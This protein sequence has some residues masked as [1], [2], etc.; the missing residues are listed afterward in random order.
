M[1]LNEAQKKG[2]KFFVSVEGHDHQVSAKQL[3]TM[4]IDSLNFKSMLVGLDNTQFIEWSEAHGVVRCSA[5]D[6]KGGVCEV[7][8][9]KGKHHSPQEWLRHQGGVCELHTVRSDRS[10]LPKHMR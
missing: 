6:E 9:N 3:S 4:E 2:I 5:P 7:A 10:M 1:D 8:L